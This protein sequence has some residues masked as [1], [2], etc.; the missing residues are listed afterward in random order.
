M[1]QYDINRL[2]AEQQRTDRHPLTCN[3][4]GEDCER[5]LIS[6]GYEYGPKHTSRGEGILIATAEG[7]VCPC[8]AYKQDY[9]S[10]NIIHSKSED[11]VEDGTTSSNYGI[12]E[13]LAEE[14]AYT[15]FILNLL[16][17]HD[18]KI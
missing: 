4:S 6:T 14:E 17:Q 8:G 16:K 18:E 11:D 5:R 12:K 3:S 9:Q 1:I 7:W 2:N 10:E 15:K 13:Y